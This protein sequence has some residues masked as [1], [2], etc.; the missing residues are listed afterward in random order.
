[1]RETMDVHS[2]D[3]QTWSTKL[4]RIGERSKH[5]RDTVFN[6]IGSVI[7]LDMLRA[8]YHS[9]ED[10]KA[11]GLDNMTK[12]KYGTKLEENLKNLLLKIRRGTYQPQATRMVE[13]PKEDGSTR[14]LAI[15][16]LEDKIVQ[17]AVNIVLGT[18][19][20][21]LFLPCS[22]GF[23]PEQSCH[24][25][26]KSLMSSTCKYPYGAVVEIDIRKYFNSIP[27]KE[28][29]EILRQ[30][31]TD[32]RFL[33]LL[34][35]LITAPSKVGEKLIANDR[36]C[37]QG[38]IISP[39][40]ANVYLHHVIDEWFESIKV[41][42][43]TGEAEL[44]RYA[45]DM[46]FVFENR[47]EAEK[48]FRVLPKRLQ[49]FGLDMHADKSSLIPSGSAAARYAYRKGKRLG[50]YNF[51]GFT[52]YWGLARNRKWWRLKFKS[53]RDRFTAKL[54]GLKKYLSENLTS[55][56]TNFVLKR[57]ARVVQGWINYHGISDNDR[58]VRG[59]I[60]AAKHT[61][62]KWFRRRGS[63]K[64]TSW[65]RFNLLLKQAGFPERW[66]TK[67]MFPNPNVAKA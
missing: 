23:R 56:D 29:N 38:S 64:K 65:Y 47:L 66:K 12:E 17:K 16:C 59:F 5:D 36:G 54:K 15:S 14:P 21:P 55:S 30:K 25:A 1:M 9:L 3:E 58:R 41:T 33:H 4:K 48:F 37:P 7:D 20:E 49:K 50:T 40:L 35:K 13:I 43:F 22:Y 67:S 10:N 57:V 51:L 27:L 61:L 46:V 19:Y 8:T 42:H 45:D 28:L 26:L 11:S 32:T 2:K 52:C 62:L 53:R 39:I 31:I 34:Q 63:R 18:I 6:N 24:D 44:I 60:M